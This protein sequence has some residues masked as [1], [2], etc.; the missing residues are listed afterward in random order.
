M[1]SQII[2]G[3][4]TLRANESD[5]IIG[6]NTELGEV[7]GIGLNFTWRINNKTPF[8]LGTV[9][10][11]KLDHLRN[12]HMIICHEL[13]EGGW[14]KADRYVRFGLDYL[15]SKQENNRYYSIVDIGTGRVGQRDGADTAA[16]RSAIANSW[17]L[18]DLFVFDSF[19]PVAIETI[20]PKVL[21]A[22]RCWD[23]QNGEIAV[24]NSARH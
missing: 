19:R 18:V 12:L 16:I 15:W 23:Y 8:A 3:D 11:F 17:L 9:L 22:Y 6:M 10:S 2:P 14:D 4:I 7:T 24:A 1:I 20:A 13:G 21:Q 5:I